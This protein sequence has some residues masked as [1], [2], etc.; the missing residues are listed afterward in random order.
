M[1]ALLCG[2]LA[3][4]APGR[5]ELPRERREAGPREQEP[6]RL[7]KRRL[8]LERGSRPPGTAA[9]GWGGGGA[10]P[11]VRPDSRPSAEGIC[12][13]EW[14]WCHHTASGPGGGYLRCR[15]RFPPAP[16][17]VPVE[18]H[19]GVGGGG[20]ARAPTGAAGQ[21]R[22]RWRRW[23]GPR[24]ADGGGPSPPFAPDTTLKGGQGLGQAAAAL[25]SLLPCPFPVPPPRPPTANIITRGARAGR[26]A[27]TPPFH[28]HG[29]DHRVIKLMIITRW[30]RPPARGRGAHPRQCAGPPHASCIPFLGVGVGGMGLARVRACAC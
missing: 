11:T 10:L 3:A 8:S 17:P 15:W 4:H 21:R 25:P 29:R 19:V 26:P 27:P 5:A 23:W 16:L 2:R 24:L 20:V 6:H 13:P 30:S 22:H 1:T 18:P 28:H 9:A 7:L 12:S 14:G